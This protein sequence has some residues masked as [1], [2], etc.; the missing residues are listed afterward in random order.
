MI[1]AHWKS[2]DGVTNTEKTQPNQQ[3]LIGKP[4]QQCMII[5]G[6]II[7]IFIRVSKQLD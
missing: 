4:P 6:M 3:Q 2:L 7:I 1:N 5:I